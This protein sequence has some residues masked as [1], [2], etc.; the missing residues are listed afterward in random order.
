MLLVRFPFCS[1][2]HTVAPLDARSIWQ[3]SAILES[4]GLKPELYRASWIAG[5]WAACAGGQI[6][7]VL[8]LK[9]KEKCRGADYCH[10]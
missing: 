7:F 3:L 10:E 1:F 2:V 9:S 5:F 4:V 8:M 6:W